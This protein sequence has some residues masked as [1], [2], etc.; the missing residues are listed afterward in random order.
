MKQDLP[1][2]TRLYEL[3]EVSG[4]FLFDNESKLLGCVAPRN[5]TEQT[6]Q[7]VVRF[8]RGPIEQA[9]LAKLGLKDLRISYEYYTVW[10]KYFSNEYNLAVFI[11]PGANLSLL[12]QPINLSALNLEKALQRDSS[13]HQPD[14]E[15]AALVMAAHQAEME[16]TE[17]L[18]S[19]ENIYFQ[20]L[21]ALSETFLG[22]VATELL[23]HALRQEQVTLPLENRPDM[24]KLMKRLAQNITNVQNKKAFLHEVDD[25]LERL[26]LDLQA[27][28]NKR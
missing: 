20:R 23:H 18:G 9:Q 14:S 10:V 5:Y 3:D 22:P 13:H 28:K 2:L 25:L 19:G 12:R 26:D 7:Q 8:L 6:I 16:I 15:T 17:N 1:A 4:V 24:E 27:A 11:R 21:A